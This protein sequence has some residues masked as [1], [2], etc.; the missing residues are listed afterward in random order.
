MNTI[1]KNISFTFFSRI[2]L[3]LLG[4]IINIIIA[5]LLGPL[6][7]GTIALMNEFFFISSTIALMGVHEANI[8][9]LGNEKFKHRDIFSNAIY[10]TIISTLL[11]YIVFF[12]IKNWL[13]HSILRNINESVFFIALGLFPA[14]F[15]QSHIIMMLLGKKNYIGYNSV[16]IV[17]PLCTVIFQL[18]LIPRLGINGAILS[19]A[20]GL[21]IADLTGTILLLRYGSPSLLPNLSY[22]R[23]AFFYGVKSQAG[24]LLSYLNRRLPIIMIN[25]YLSTVSVG[26]FAL[27]LTIAEFAWYIPESVGVILFPEI[28]STNKEHAGRVAALA[29]RNT[30]FIISVVG[31][32]LII[33]ADFIIKLFFGPSFIPSIPILRILVPG[34][35]IFSV[36]RVLCSYFAGTGKP[37]YGTYTSLASFFFLFTL[38]LILVPKIGLIGAPIASLTAFIVSSIL[39]I[40]IFMRSSKI[41]FKDITIIKK[42]DFKKYSI[43]INQITQKVIK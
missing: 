38:I 3:L 1:F 25:L 41:G 42:E 31:L 37:E 10:Q 28:S 26:Y 15:Y 20:I 40:I 17:Q 14:F 22:W 16:L 18:I 11:V 24:L 2:I 27:A 23:T 39:S 7:K 43:I 35:V 29:T 13:L 9:F 4:V 19:I 5:R 36:N 34:I 21:F 6:G 32:L 12:I 33:G 30:L 8:Y